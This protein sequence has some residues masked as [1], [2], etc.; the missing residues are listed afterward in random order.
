MEERQSC[1]HL[2]V[3][4]SQCLASAAQNNH[5]Y[6]W[7]DPLHAMEQENIGVALAESKNPYLNQE[8]GPTFRVI[9]EAQIL[10]FAGL[11]TGGSDGPTRDQV[12]ASLF[13]Y[14]LFSAAVTKTG[15]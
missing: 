13:I 14:F 15:G 1:S 9:G 11:Y 2:D 7:E 12:K 6:Q 3:N 5:Q 4:I 8:R 10:C